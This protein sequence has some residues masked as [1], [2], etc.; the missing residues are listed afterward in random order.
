M[1]TVSTEHEIVSVQASLMKQKPPGRAVQRILD[2]T[3]GI[4]R[5]GL[6]RTRGS[7]WNPGCAVSN[8]SIYWHLMN[9]LRYTPLRS[10]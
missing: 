4:A 10:L 3:N 1:R 7:F 8:K 5:T 6:G 2:C 9:R